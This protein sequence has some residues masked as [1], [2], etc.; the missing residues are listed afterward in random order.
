MLF[1]LPPLETIVATLKTLKISQREIARLAGISQATVAQLYAGR[2][3]QYTTVRK[4]A[5]GIERELKN[6][7]SSRPVSEVCALGLVTVGPN[8]RVSKARD[9]MLNNHFDQL[10]VFRGT[11]AIGSVVWED[12]VRALASGLEYGSAMSRRV[13]EIMRPP[14]PIVDG[15]ESVSVAQVL[16]LYH[17]AVLVRLNGIVEGI[18]T[19]TDLV[20][21]PHKIG[22]K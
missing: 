12:L 7:R 13:Q 1:N 21:S 14:F 8:D 20:R 19:W 10:P 17:P 15:T 9:L 5:L 11:E 18:A 6:R 22:P 3:S 4:L 2:D 16:L